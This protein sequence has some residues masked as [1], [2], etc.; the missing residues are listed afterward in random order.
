MR[1]MCAY[2]YNTTQPRHPT[3]ADLPTVFVLLP[4]PPTLHNGFP[5]PPSSAKSCLLHEPSSRPY[6]SNAGTTPQG[7]YP[8]GSRSLYTPCN[9]RHAQGDPLPC[10]SLEAVPPRRAMSGPLPRLFPSSILFDSFISPFAQRG[11]RSPDVV[12]VHCLWR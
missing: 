12:H 8:F 10:L 7:L 6:L 3:P 11:F 9:R 2:T 5:F 1:T 4:S